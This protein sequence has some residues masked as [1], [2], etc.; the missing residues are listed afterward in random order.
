[1]RETV[2]RVLRGQLVLTLENLENSEEE[3]DILVGQ[4]GGSGLQRNVSPSKAVK[5]SSAELKTIVPTRVYSL[6]NVNN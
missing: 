6:F 3:G 4:E 1:V 2:L 5:S